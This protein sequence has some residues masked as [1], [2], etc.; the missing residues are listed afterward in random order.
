MPREIMTLRLDRSTRR[1]LDAVARR[2][3]RTPSAVARAAL[4]S[5]LDGDDG[6]VAEMP[7]ALVADLIGCVSGGDPRRSTRGARAIADALRRA[8]RRRSRR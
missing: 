5:W 6:R 3:G 8:R 2:S 1:R 7:H 4:E